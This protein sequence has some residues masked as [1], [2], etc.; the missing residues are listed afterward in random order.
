MLP[1]CPGFLCPPKTDVTLKIAI[2]SKSNSDLS[3][4]QL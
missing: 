1:P 4:I 2:G 3:L